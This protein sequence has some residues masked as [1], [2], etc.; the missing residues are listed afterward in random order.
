MRDRFQQVTFH[1]PQEKF[2]KAGPQPTL[3][4]GG[5]GAGKSYIGIM[6]MLYLLDEYPGSRGV[7][8]RQRFNQLKKTTSATLWKML[9]KDHVARRNDNEGVVQLTNGSQL[10]LMHLDK[11]DSIE[12]MKSL[13]LNFAYVDQAED[14]SSEAYDVLLERVGRWS[15][16]LKRGGWPSDWLYITET[17]EPIPPPYVFISAYSPGYDH[18]ITSRFWENGGERERYRKEGYIYFTGSTR[19]NPNLTK[20]YVKGRLSM[21]QE[22]VDRYVD[23]ISWGANEGAIFNLSQD[24]ILEP[25]E[26]LLNKI[27]NRMRLH[28]VMD[29]GE[30]SPTACLWYATDSEQNVYYYREYHVPGLLVSEHRRNIY[31]LSKSDC[32]NVQQPKYYSNLADP[33]IFNKTRGRSVNSPPQWSVADEWREARIVDKET[34]VAWRPAPNDEAMTITRVREYLR[35]DETHRHPVTGKMGAP[36]AYFIKRTKDYPNGCHEV[37]VDVRSAKRVEI[38]TNADGSKQFGDERDDSVR[39][40]LLDCV[41]YSIGSRPAL[42]LKLEEHRDKP[43]W[44][45]LKD[46]ED[47]TEQVAA[48]AERE[49]ILNY[50]G[51]HRY[52]Y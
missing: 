47:Y 11:A 39:D 40:H 23:A 26:E 20:H 33:S 3:F 21:G 4:L 2:F 46:Y 52:G 44:I 42:G 12:N 36:R 49:R 43:G 22:Y 16:A 31:E 25:T 32:T 17:G 19:E 7:I 5:V 38:G 51:K 6:K 14:V 41:R 28:R 37:L 50:R 8:V 27:R 9:P 18:W 1:G 13:E 10:L 24:S 35:I 30:F 34:S 45:K 29:H 48:R 15:G